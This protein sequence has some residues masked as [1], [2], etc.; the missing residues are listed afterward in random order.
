[1]VVTQDTLLPIG[2]ELDHHGKKVRILRLVGDGFTSE[3]YE[4]EMYRDQEDERLQVAVKALKPLDF[5]MAKQNFQAEAETLASLMEFEEQ[6][7]KT[8]GVALKIAPI[9]YGYSEHQKTPYIVMEFIR[10]VE[11][12]ELLNRSKKLPE[13]QALTIAWQFFRLLDLL[14]TRLKKYFVD[15]KSEN[16]WWV[17]EENRPDGQLKITD[18]GTLAEIKNVGQNFISGEKRD[19]LLG[20]SILYYMVSGRALHYSIYGKLLNPEDKAIEALPVSWG[21]KEILSRGLHRSPERR[22]QKASEAASELR[23]LVEWWY[24]PG[25]QVY[26]KANNNLNE[27]LKFENLAGVEPRKYARRTQAALS[28][29]QLK[30]PQ[31]RPDEVGAAIRQAEAVLVKSDYLAFGKDLLIGG[32]YEDAQRQ[33]ELGKDW[34][35]NTAELRRWGYLAEALKGH[36]IPPERFEQIRSEAMEIIEL[37]NQQQ[38]GVAKARLNLLKDALGNRGLAYL[39]A[40]CDLFENLFRAEKAGRNEQFEVAAENYQLGWEALEKLPDRE[41]VM[42]EEVG[43]LQHKAIEAKT[44]AETRGEALKALRDADQFLNNAPLEFEKLA[45]AYRKA[46]DADAHCPGLAV[47]ISKGVEMAVEKGEFKTALQLIEIGLSVDGTADLMRGE[48][49]VAAMSSVDRAL[50]RGD[51][52]KSI[53]KIDSLVRNFRSMHGATRAIERLLKAVEESATTNQQPDILS[54]V[55]RLYLELDPS[56]V[57]IAQQIEARAI[58]IREKQRVEAQKVIDLQIAYVSQDLLYLQ[59]RDLIAPA[60]Y[61]ELALA[62]HFLQERQEC[63]QEAAG[64]L[65]RLEMMSPAWDNYRFQEIK[66][67]SAQLNSEKNKPLREDESTLLQRKEAQKARKTRLND[68]WENYNRTLKWLQGGDRVGLRT[69]TTMA[70][71]AELAEKLKE[72]Y[73]LGSTYLAIQGEPDE[74]VQEVLDQVIGHIDQ[75]GLAGWQALHQEAQKM[76]DEFAQQIQKAQSDLDNGRLEEAIPQIQ[77]LQLTAGEDPEVIQLAQK[78]HQIQ[79]FLGWVDSNQSALQMGVGDSQILEGINHLTKMGIPAVYWRN[80]LIPTFLDTL[81]KRYRQQ[82]Q[83]GLANPENYEFIQ[84]MRDYTE[85]KRIINNLRTM[86]QKG[87]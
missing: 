84:T 13:Q 53:E 29:L 82:L 43:N 52:D 18:F 79:R 77:E 5:A 54:A 32:S 17:G 47:G 25:E 80:S 86:N 20:M 50:L 24:R 12:P 62:N 6:A 51:L 26:D 31:F 30:D 64:I 63:L 87:G 36:R 68:K 57:E 75:L 44:L 22:Y 15:L 8:Q 14:H 59:S 38:W 34:A 83:Q 73:L 71:R 70:M 76:L 74:T 7:N 85:L 45:Q 69:E 21:L 40:E 56:E 16:L 72:I 78:A 55:S 58:Q 41:F 9:Y 28:I 37:M 2:L 1:M 49:M 66:A 65:T 35:S 67:L 61:P 4:A 23:S 27:A 11:L 42:R 10:G 33:F 39:L 46:V 81:N 19:L 60:I 48:Q 3:V